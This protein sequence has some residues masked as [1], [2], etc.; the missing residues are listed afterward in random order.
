MRQKMQPHPPLVTSEPHV[1]LFGI[2]NIF[3]I[4]SLGY[5]LDWVLSVLL[6]CIS[7]KLPFFKDS[8]TSQVQ[9]KSLWVPWARKMSLSLR[10]RCCGV[11]AVCAMKATLGMKGLW[12]KREAKKPHTLL[13]Q[14]FIYLLFLT[15]W[16]ASLSE[17]NHLTITT[18][19][20]KQPHDGNQACAQP[21]KKTEKRQS[22]WRFYPTSLAPREFLPDSWPQDGLL[23]ALA[24]SLSCYWT[25]WSVNI[26]WVK[27]EI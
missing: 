1:L 15:M 4:N 3:C 7:F 22:K 16:I 14:D 20:R 24:L 12:W 13:L 27:A 9:G 25:L 11:S 8:L 6:K 2:C 18:T 5:D 19:F 17:F 10:F 23:L 26:L 21:R